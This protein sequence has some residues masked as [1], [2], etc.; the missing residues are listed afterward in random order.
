MAR[1]CYGVSISRFMIP[2]FF[3]SPRFSASTLVSPF[4]TSHLCHTLV[5][6]V[7]T[8]Y[9]SKVRGRT[10]GFPLRPIMESLKPGFD[11]GFFIRLLLLP[12]TELCTQVWHQAEYRVEKG[13]GLD[14]IIQTPVSHIAA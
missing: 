3:L 8:K 6:T 2:Y 4:V 14:N 10:W 1:C 12:P 5:P 9:Q 7:K 11:N 13:Q